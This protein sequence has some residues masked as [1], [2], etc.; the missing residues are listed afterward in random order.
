MAAGG[1]GGPASA[2][3]QASGDAGRRRRGAAGDAYRQRP[4]PPCAA[5]A[6]VRRPPCPCLRVNRRFLPW[7]I[8]P[9]RHIHLPPHPPLAGPN[10]GVFL[11]APSS[12]AVPPQSF[13]WENPTHKSLD[14]AFATHRKWEII[15]LP[16]HPNSAARWETS[17]FLSANL[18]ICKCIFGVG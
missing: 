17:Q 9:N 11:T 4:A 12:E 16:M 14:D 1:G 13:G 8:P 5:T 10:P 2:P 3:P 7:R 15:S 18:Q 6:G